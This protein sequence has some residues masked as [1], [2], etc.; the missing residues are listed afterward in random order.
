M[1]PPTKSIARPARRNLR[2]TLLMISNFGVSD[3]GR[4]TWAYNFIPRMLERW[5]DV[6]LDIIGLNRSGE[7]DNIPR[8]KALAPGRIGVTFLHSKRKSLPT[9]TV[10]RDAP[11]HLSKGLHHTPDLV[12]G[13]GSWMELLVVLRSPALNRAPRIVWLR[14]IWLHEK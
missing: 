10:L 12:I 3:G 9:L 8:L 4:E 6:L 1:T 14:T 5:P 2:I 11:V 13:V 7:P